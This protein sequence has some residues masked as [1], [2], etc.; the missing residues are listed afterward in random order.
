M[1]KSKVKKVIH[2]IIKVLKE[3]NEASN[4]HAIDYFL[5]YDLRRINITMIYLFDSSLTFILL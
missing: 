1:I 5:T 4:Y 3:K 2:V